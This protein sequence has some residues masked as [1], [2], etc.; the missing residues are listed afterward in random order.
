MR[1]NKGFTLVELMI[2]VVILGV[3]MGTILPR[4]TG[5]QA[6]ARDT[7]RVADL[8]NIAAALQTYYDDYGTFPGTSAT[9][10]CLDEAAGS[11]Q[12][13]AGYLKGDA[14][15]RDPSAAGNGALC[16]GAN[17]GE[18]YYAPLVK[19]GISAN[20]YIL[21]TDMETY[22]KA[23]TD[24]GTIT[25]GAASPLALAGAYDTYTEL[26]AVVG[27]ASYTAEDTDAATDS[28]YCVLGE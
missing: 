28:A 14:V 27:A 7:A 26:S 17:V 4:L 6:R 22:Q 21:C 18:Y 10:E 2:V 12:A 5:A 15:P 19:D 1:N 8:G 9:S 16:S 23:N 3:L 11:G 13:I 24:G 25:T 20:S